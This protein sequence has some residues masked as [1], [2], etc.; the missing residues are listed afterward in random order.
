MPKKLGAKRTNYEL[1]EVIFRGGTSYYAPRDIEVKSLKT[2]RARVERFRPKG[3]KWVII[4]VEKTIFAEIGELE[5]I[6]Q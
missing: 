5:R 1:A 2:A 3:E 4:K 6:E